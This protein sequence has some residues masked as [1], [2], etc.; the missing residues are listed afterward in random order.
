MLC[1]AKSHAKTAYRIIPIKGAPVTEQQARS[2]LKTGFV[3]KIDPSP[4]FAPLVTVSR[5]CKGAGSVGTF[6]TDALIYPYMG[7]FMDPETRE[8]KQII[9]YHT[10]DLPPLRRSA[11]RCRFDTVPLMASQPIFPIFLLGFPSER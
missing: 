4:L 7:F 2:T 5:A 1:K 11:I 6:R 9:H 8:R 10:S 3:C